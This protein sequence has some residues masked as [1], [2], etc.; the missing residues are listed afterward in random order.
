MENIPRDFLP[1]GDHGLEA[2]G[3]GGSKV[4]EF[5]AVLG[6]IVEFPLLPFEGYQLPVA[7]AEAEVFC[8]LQE[9]WFGSGEAGILDDGEE[10]HSGDGTKLS[11]WMFGGDSAF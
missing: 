7:I 11:G 10:G 5:C 8:K 9:E 6:D 4:V 2:F 1:L 3:F